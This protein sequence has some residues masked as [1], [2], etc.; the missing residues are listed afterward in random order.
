MEWDGTLDWLYCLGLCPTERD[1]GLLNGFGI[2]VRAYPISGVVSVSR[3]YR[4]YK[5]YG[6][7]TI[8]MGASF[9]NLGMCANP[10]WA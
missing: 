5:K 2:V 3:I 10:P 8:V 1:V 6:Y 4:Y 7:K 9:R